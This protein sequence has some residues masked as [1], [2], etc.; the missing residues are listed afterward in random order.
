MPVGPGIKNHVP[1][2]DAD[3]KAE[4]ALFQFRNRPFYPRLNHRR[5]L[6]N[7]AIIV[8]L[9]PSPGLVRASACPRRKGESH[10]DWVDLPRW[11]MTPI[12]IVGGIF[13]L[14]AIGLI[15]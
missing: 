4:V 3:C 9:R 5:G 8:P 13:G 14:F 10:C 15:V 6:G 1:H 11:H 12:E 7:G 2:L